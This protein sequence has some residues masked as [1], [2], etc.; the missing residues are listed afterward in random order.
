VKSKR[1][2]PSLASAGVGYSNADETS[3]T[4]GIEMRTRG[5]GPAGFM[6]FEMQFGTDSAAFE[7]DRSAEIVRILGTV[8]DRIHRQGIEPGDARPI[9]DINGNNIGTFS[10]GVRG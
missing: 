6:K 4:G 3:H 10:L 5:E 7:E 2:V 9:L 1:E 8:A